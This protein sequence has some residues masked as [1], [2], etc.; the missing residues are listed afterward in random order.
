MH[1]SSA[2]LLILAVALVGILHTL[3]PDHWAPIV[4]LARQRG[5]TTFEVARIAALA[6]TG[7]TVTTLVIATIV[8][9]GG[10]AVA[11][12]FGNLMS[13]LSSVALVSFGAWIALGSLR[14]MRA[15]GHAEHAHLEH[16]HEHRHPS[17][18]A[19]RHRHLHHETD[20]HD[21]EGSVAL[22]AHEHSHD[23]SSRTAL[24][25]VLGSSPMIEGIPAFFAAARYGFFLL[26][27]MAVVFAAATIATYVALCVVSS[28]GAARL[29]LGPFERY[30]EV[31]SG[32]FIALLGLVFLFF[33]RL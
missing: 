2:A 33:P 12:R 27:I 13:L 19:H 4:L 32:S 22:P 29:R 15:G 8:W 24:L 21:V 7:H 23:P 11:T 20:W 18:L 14:E 26:G 10:L 17:G 25:L 6:G 30:G 16:A 5:W 28:R 1:F 9:L 31:L 3:V